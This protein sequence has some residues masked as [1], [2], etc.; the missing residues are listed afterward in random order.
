VRLWAALVNLRGQ[1]EALQSVLVAVAL[2]ASGCAMTTPHE[3]ALL[4]RC[5]RL[6]A[7]VLRLRG[8]RRTVTPSDVAAMQALRDRGMYAP[9]IAIELGFGVSTVYR[10]T[11]A[12]GTRG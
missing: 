11:T 10:W 4:A 9:E 7:E 8:V 5:L 3:R 12:G 2:D 1:D 6:E